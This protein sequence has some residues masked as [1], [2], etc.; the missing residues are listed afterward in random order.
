M[1]YEKEI[2][3][4]KSEN[5]SLK[6]EIKILFKRVENCEL[7]AMGFDPNKKRNAYDLNENCGTKRH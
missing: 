4:L 2:K 5:E 1:D 3:E 7:R 6:K